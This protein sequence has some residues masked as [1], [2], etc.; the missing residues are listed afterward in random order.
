MFRYESRS[1]KTHQLHVCC[2]INE[3]LS[4]SCQWQLFAAQWISWLIG[5]FFFFSP[6]I[7]NEGVKCWTILCTSWDWMCRKVFLWETKETVQRLTWELHYFLAIEC[8]VSE[9]VFADPRE[10]GSFLCFKKKGKI[11]PD[12][13]VV[14]LAVHNSPIKFRWKTMV[15]W[16]FCCPPLLLFLFVLT[17]IKYLQPNVHPRGKD[18]GLTMS[19]LIKNQL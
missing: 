3:H 11:Q 10:S 9:S 2:E 1:D 12:R 4:S 7:P 8:H 6:G 13:N 18:F 15:C 14:I 17:V 19:I 16:C 5:L